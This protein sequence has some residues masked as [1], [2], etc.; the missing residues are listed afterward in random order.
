MKKNIYIFIVIYIICVLCNVFWY[1]LS[2]SSIL[3]C[4]RPNTHTVCVVHILRT[5]SYQTPWMMRSSRR[6]PTSVR[7][8]AFR[9]LSGGT[10]KYLFVT[11][12]DEI[13]ERGNYRIFS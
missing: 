2:Q 10:L 12:F 13:I 3:F 11:C 6:L 9:R 5:T 7:R 8:I 1:S 4:C